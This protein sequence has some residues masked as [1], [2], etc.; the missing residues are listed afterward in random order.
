ME[1]FPA[2][3]G[4]TPGRAG[5]AWLDELL[6]QQL[7]RSYYLRLNLIP[8]FLAQLWALRLAY[9]PKT[10]PRRSQV[11]PHVIYRKA[12]PHLHSLFNIAFLRLLF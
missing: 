4:V 3:I 9:P 1:Q 6:K 11:R 8:T 2:I 7:I 5:E 12:L 10:D